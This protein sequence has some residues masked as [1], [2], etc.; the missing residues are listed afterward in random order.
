M[1]KQIDR[2]VLV[3][4][5]RR[6]MEARQIDRLPRSGYA[7][8]IQDIDGCPASDAEPVLHGHW[9]L[10]DDLPPWFEC[11]ECGNTGMATEYCPGCGAK[12]DGGEDN[13]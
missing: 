1:G 6:M 3:D 7:K 4:H 9:I 2:D 10:H 5:L 8:A 13:G 12:M 11:S